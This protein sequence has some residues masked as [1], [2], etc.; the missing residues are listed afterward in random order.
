MAAESPIETGIRNGS[1]ATASS[2]SATGRRCM[3]QARPSTTIP[4][5]TAAP[6]RR[7]ETFGTSRSDARVASASTAHAGAASMAMAR[8]RRS[9]TTSAK[10][11]A[12]AVTVS[13][14]P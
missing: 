13:T 4:A 12:I 9:G 3:S 5:A 14:A 11:T 8:R 10:A 6:A 2:G 1:A 7:G